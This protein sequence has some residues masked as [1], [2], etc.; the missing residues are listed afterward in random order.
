MQFHSTISEQ[1][2]PS[3]LSQTEKIWGQKMNNSQLWLF[4]Y[5]PVCWL[6]WV[7]AFWSRLC[8]YSAFTVQFVLIMW[9]ILSFFLLF[10]VKKKAFS[11]FFLPLSFLFLNFCNL[12]CLELIY[13]GWGGKYL[14]RISWE[15]WPYCSMEKWLP[16]WGNGKLQTEPH[17]HTFSSSF[18]PNDHQVC[19]ITWDFQVDLIVN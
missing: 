13:I 8:N 5:W 17:S 12:K 16:C 6:S 7:H 4:G 14:L 3:K 15:P 10:S 19:I 9:A 18:H 11:S 2:H 1:G